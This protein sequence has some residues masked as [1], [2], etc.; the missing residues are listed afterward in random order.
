MGN[1][2]INGHEYDIEMF[3]F[4]KDGLMFESRQ[5]W[6]ELAQARIRA[7]EKKYPHV[8][9]EF[10]MNWMKFCG[11]ATVQE[12]EKVK[13]E[14]VS[15]L[16]ILAVA[17][18]PEEI[19]SSAAYFAEHLELDWPVARNMARDIFATGDEMFD[20]AASLKPRPGFPEIFHRL[21]AA[22]IPYGVATSDTRERVILSLDMFD[23]F[24]YAKITVTVDD[25]ERGKP[26]PD[27]LIMISEKMGVPL[28]K[29]A[30]LGDS[31]VDV[32]MA[33]AAG[34]VGIGIPE[35][36]DII[37]KMVGI[38]TEIVSSLDDIEFVS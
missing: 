32:A 27:M 22:G 16:G 5:F 34:S 38:A 3:V 17:P 21:R 25:V 28:N 24:E 6:I 36:E 8:S 33:K 13:V 1:V 26:N 23:R 35:Q 30:M 31:Y 20:L 37:P 19:I 4:D 12:G 2:R 15:P 14:D 29:I 7:A 9:G 10:L 11:V 18:V